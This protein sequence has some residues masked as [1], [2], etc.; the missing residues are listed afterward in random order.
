MNDTISQADPLVLSRD[1][2][3]RLA[4]NV[5]DDIKAIDAQA[6]AEAA[7]LQRQIDAVRA[8]QAK[9]VSELRAAV[10]KM[11]TFAEPEPTLSALLPPDRRN[12]P[13]DL[14][15]SQEAALQRLNAAHDLQD[16][17]E[18]L[19]PPAYQRP[20]VQQGQVQS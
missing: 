17:E 18:G 7:D 9:T 15:P 3:K 11:W 19:A 13:P 2:I 6:D 10:T 4:C 16:A 20:Y 5:D 12:Y 1:T 8:K 14:D